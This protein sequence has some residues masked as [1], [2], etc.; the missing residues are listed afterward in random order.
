MAINL[1]DMTIEDPHKTIKLIIEMVC[2]VA[3]LKYGIE[4]P[5]NVGG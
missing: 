2:G 5:V 1:Q 4:L 3:N